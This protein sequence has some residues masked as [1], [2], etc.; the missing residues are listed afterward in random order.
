[1]SD[2]FRVGGAEF[3]LDPDLD[4]ATTLELADPAMH[5]LLHFAAA[6]ITI[7]VGARMV[8]DAAAP[9]V[10]LPITAAV[11]SR[12]PYDPS[13][14]LMTGH[15]KLPALCAA[16]QGG[17]SERRSVARSC[18]TTTIELTYVMPP[19]SPAQAQR[20]LPY[21]SAIQKVLSNRLE[22]GHDPDYAP[23]G[24]ELNDPVWTLAGIDSIALTGCKYGDFDGVGE[25]AFPA[26]VMTLVVREK[27]GPPHGDPIDGF[28]TTV[29]LSD[30]PTNTV[31]LPIAE[32][33]GDTNVPP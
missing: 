17:L 24:G 14:H 23:P 33:N 18:E 7:Y 32:V 2:T 21:L 22:H 15:M 1:M 5:R 27:N 16:R 29:N 8:A 6:V 3:P 4:L 28:D 30:A 26:V 11:Q 19:M 31:V 12:L 25:L 13:K 9:G 10:G 20:M